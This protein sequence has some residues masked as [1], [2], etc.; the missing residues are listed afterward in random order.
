MTFGERLKRLREQR[1]ISQ[2]KLADIIGVSRAVISS[3]ECN[4]SKP[5]FEHIV[6]ISK[7][8]NT[9]PNKLFNVS[10]IIDN[11]WMT[12]FI[13][14]TRDRLASSN[15]TGDNIA[16]TYYSFVINGVEKEKNR[17]ENLKK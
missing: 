3:Y 5:K 13:Y 14:T 8:L 17:I 1:D 2:Q 11:E 4:K 6:P 7:A 12:K 9:S 10:E 15:N 16:A